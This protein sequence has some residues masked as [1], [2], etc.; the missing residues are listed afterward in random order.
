MEA[1]DDGNEDD[2]DG[3]SNSCRANVNTLASGD[4]NNC[5][6]RD[7]FAYCMGY[8]TFGVSGMGPPPIAA[9]RLGSFDGV[10]QVAT[11]A[12]Q[13]RP[14]RMVRCGVKQQLRAL[15]DRTIIQR[16]RPSKCKVTDAIQ[17][18]SGIFYVRLEANGNGRLLGRASRQ[19]GNGLPRITTI[20][21]SL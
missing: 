6:V 11:A 19:L 9:P 17:I 20:H 18:T 21:R 10:V 4:T 8:N 16:N 2:G 5:F 14:R 13:L 1:C 7:G 12:A 15:G 3:C